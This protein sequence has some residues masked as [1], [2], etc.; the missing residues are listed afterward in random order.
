MGV[1]SRRSDGHKHNKHS[2]EVVVAPLQNVVSHLVLFV[3]FVQL[4]E[5]IIPI[6]TPHFWVSAQPS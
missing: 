2:I 4:D 6:R 1:L 3:G 5:P